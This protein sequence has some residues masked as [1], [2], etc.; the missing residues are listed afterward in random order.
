MRAS[1]TAVL[2]L[3]LLALIGC[4]E[5]VERATDAAGDCEPIGEPGSARSC[6]DGCVV[7]HGAI[8]NATQPCQQG[9]TIVAGCYPNGPAV[10]HSGAISCY[11][12]A[13]GS[14]V[15]QTVAIFPEL[16]EQG[17]ELCSP[18]VYDQTVGHFCP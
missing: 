10:G 6:P 3:I 13:D 11:T 12:T 1:C 5:D 17:W 18:E 7:I 8:R 4:A 16:M 9:P 14:L 2:S 15:V